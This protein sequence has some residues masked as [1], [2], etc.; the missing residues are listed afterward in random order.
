MKFLRNILPVD[1]RGVALLV[2]VV[3][4]L[5][6]AILASVILSLSSNQTRIVEHDI[7][8]IKSKYADEA[9]MVRQLD[10]LRRNAANETSHPVTGRYD[11]DTQT[12]TVGVQKGPGPLGS[13]EINTTTNY[14]AAF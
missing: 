6:L 1:E 2:V 8:R 13:V 4:V 10:I 11:S 14:T 5:I 9:A 12:W 3:M 7:S